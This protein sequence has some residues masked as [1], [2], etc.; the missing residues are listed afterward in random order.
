MHRMHYVTRRSH[1]MQKHRF[2]VMCLDMFLV[3]SIPVPPE[4]E[5]KCVDIS[6]PR[7]TEIHYVTRRTHRMQKHTFGVTCPD[8]IFVESVPVPT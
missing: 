1:G 7:C 5:K 4:Y 3:E 8:M 6:H 2:D